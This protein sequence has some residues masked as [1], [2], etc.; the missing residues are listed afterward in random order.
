MVA[1]N[2]ERKGKW[3]WT[4]S[5]AGE[6]ITVYAGSDAENEALFI[7]D[8]IETTAA[9]RIP[10]SAWRCCTAPIPSRGR[11]K[12]RCGATAAST[13]WSAASASTSAPKSRTSIAYLKLALAPQDSISLLRII[14]TPARGIGKTTVEQ[15]EQYALRTTLSL[16]TAIGRM[17]D[18]KQF[19]AARAG[20]AGGVPQ[21]DGRAGRGGRGR[22]P[23]HEAL[24]VYRRTHRLPRDA[25]AGEHARSRRR[26][27]RT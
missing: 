20:G 24:Q 22:M 13:W 17:I 6:Q 3:L 12:K 7:A 16:W 10:T 15:I 27:S 4:E 23:L 19:P 25:G 18:E 9:R 26:A 5:G 21:H 1:N 11:S 14:N 8:T 2:T